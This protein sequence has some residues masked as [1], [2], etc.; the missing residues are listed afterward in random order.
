MLGSA[1]W[2]IEVSSSVMKAPLVTTPSGSQRLSKVEA[3]VSEAPQH[4]LTLHDASRTPHM[5]LGLERR[6]VSRTK[7]SA[8]GPQAA[9]ALHVRCRTITRRD[10]SGGRARP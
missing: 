10:G 6:A 7:R 4:A 8:D 9:G 5:P 1:T 3:L 2:T